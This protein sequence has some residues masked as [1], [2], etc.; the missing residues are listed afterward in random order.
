[1]QLILAKPAKDGITA[2]AI[3]PNWTRKDSFFSNFL[4]FKWDW[5]E[6]DFTNVRDISDPFQFINLVPLT[7]HQH[8]LKSWSNTYHSTVSLICLKKHVREKSKHFFK[9]YNE[10]E[11]KQTRA[12]TKI[13][14]MIRRWGTPQNFIILHMCTKNHNH[15]RY[16]SFDPPNNPKNQKF[17]KIKKM[18]GD[19]IILHLCATNY[20]HMIYGSWD[21]KRYRHN[22][23]SFWTIFCP[24][25]PLTTKKIKIL[26][27]WKKLLE[28]N[29][30]HMSTINKNHMYDSW[31]ME[32]NRHIFFSFWTIFCP[33]TPPPL[34]T[35]RIKILKKW[36]KK[37]ARDI[38]ILHKC[39]IND[40]HMIYGSWDVNCN[41]F[42]W[43]TNFFC[44]L[45]PFLGLLPT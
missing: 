43:D 26:K 29:I 10:K 17:E 42:F 1:M 21:I 8:F 19:I 28:V 24:F 7:K 34:I 11:V 6:V 9:L 37:P 41:F 44:H 5:R 20:D 15:M 40:N 35:Q 4:A 22:F 3:L 31:D 13:T 33:F 16:S 38:I 36:K 45:G 2:Y 18:P 30:L 23:L 25:T 27:K 14:N 32:R 12:I 39:T